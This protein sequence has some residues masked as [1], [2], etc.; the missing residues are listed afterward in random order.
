VSK[1]IEQLI[2]FSKNYLDEKKFFQKASKAVPAWSKLVQE[3]PLSFQSLLKLPENYKIVG[4]IGKGNI[5]DVP[6][7]CVLDTDVTLS[8]QSGYYIV[9]LF[10]VDMSGFYI[11]LNQGWTQ[12]E[13]AYGTSKGKSEIQQ[14]AQISQSS[15]RT[16]S[17]FELARLSLGANRSLAKGYESGNIASQYF[18]LDESLSESDIYQCIFRLLSAYS[19]LKGI[20]GD[21]IL[22]IKSLISEESYQNTIQNSNNKKIPDGPIGKKQ[23]NL[24]KSSTSWY[25][26]PSI[27]KIALEK[28]GFSCE[29]DKEHETFISKSSGTRFFEAHHLIPMEYQK[30][31]KYSLDVPENIVSLCPNCHRRVHLS[32]PEDRVSLVSKLIESRIELLRD[33]GVGI[34]MDFIID[35]YS[36]E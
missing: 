3:I 21:N 28:S 27:S 24:N 4:S 17:G 22:N 16:I 35:I 2:D 12:Y 19:E 5:T 8:P 32:L 18:N 10:K 30:D 33:R 20:V 26:D 9:V 14:N 6:W 29:I 34:D 25:R 15:L 36:K 31:F 7:L 13:K 11:S 23:G 1:L